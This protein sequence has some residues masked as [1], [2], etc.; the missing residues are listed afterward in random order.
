MGVSVFQLTEDRHLTTLPSSSGSSLLTLPSPGEPGSEPLSSGPSF[1][2][3]DSVSIPEGEHTHTPVESQTQPPTYVYH[4][5]SLDLQC[6]SKYRP[7][8]S[9][10]PFLLSPRCVWWTPVGL[11]WQPGEREV[12]HEGHSSQLAARQQLQPHPI[13]IVSTVCPSH[14]NKLFACSIN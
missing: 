3:Q 1:P 9:L 13:P 12:H 4:S 7:L 2:D 10:T 6:V 14:L 11:Q 5:L 8:W